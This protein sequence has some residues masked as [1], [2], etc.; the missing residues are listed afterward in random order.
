MITR[1]SEIE[2]NRWRILCEEAKAVGIDP[3]YPKFDA[4]FRAI[5]LWGESLSAFRQT[6]TKQDREKAASIAVERYNV[7]KKKK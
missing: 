3:N 5:A 7:V 6:Q 1:E 2:Y 4:L